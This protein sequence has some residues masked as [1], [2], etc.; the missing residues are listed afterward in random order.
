MSPLRFWD[1]LTLSNKAELSD[2]SEPEPHHV[3]SFFFT[4]QGPIVSTCPPVAT[5][6]CVRAS[7]TTR[8]P[9]GAASV[10][11]LARHLRFHDSGAASLLASALDPIAARLENSLAAVPSITIDGWPSPSGPFTLTTSVPANTLKIYVFGAPLSGATAGLGGSQS[12]E[13]PGNRGESSNKFA[14]AVAY[15]EFDDDGSTNWYF[16]SSTTSGV[17]LQ[18]HQTALTGTEDSDFVTIAIHEFLHGLGFTQGDPV[19]AS[20]AKNGYFTGPNA[21]QAN[22]NTAVPLSSDGSH[23]ASTVSSVMNPSLTEGVRVPMSALEYGFL[24]DIGWSVG[25]AAG[26]YRQWD[27][28]TGGSSGSDVVQVFPLRGVYLM[29]VDALSGDNL[30]LTTADGTASNLKSVSSYLKL[31]DANGNVIA[32]SGPA[33]GTTKASLNW[34]FVNGGTFYVGAS[35][36]SQ[37]GFTLTGSSTTFNSSQGFVLN[38]N[39]DGAVDN[40]PQNIVSANNPFSIG[41]NGYSSTNIVT[42]VSSNVYAIDTVPGH[43]YQAATFL[44]SGGGFAGP[45]I[46]SI[47][48]GSGNKLAGMTAAPADSDVSGDYGQTSFAA[49]TAGPYY[50][51]VQPYLGDN[52]IAPN[53]GSIEVG[54]GVITSS[55]EFSANGDRNSGSDYA[56]SITDTSAP[57]FRGETRVMVRTG[58]KPSQKTIEYQLSFS[59]ALDP[60]IAKNPHFF[61]VFQM[62]KAGKHRVK[63]INVKVASVTLGSGATSISLR[64]GQFKKNLPLSLQLSGLLGSTGVAVEPV[65]TTL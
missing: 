58:R 35:A 56:I 38:A 27:L 30:S 5:C 33:T 44:P 53:Q 48:D 46:I 34:H 37:N 16:G 61:H 26:L 59:S 17:D 7:R 14:P 32:A 22:H 63:Q 10:G 20:Y 36:V 54:W 4:F 13:I 15:I 28:F 57:V 40:A 24:E 51:I 64:L 47:Y 52:K 60:S 45:A 3:W 1:R 18:G 50:V 42:D 49:A 41:P 31:F 19:F 55:G 23:V 2:E 25:S 62:Q 43:T 12:G 65:S 39:L 29:R 9:G 11:L 21:D 6:R 8:T